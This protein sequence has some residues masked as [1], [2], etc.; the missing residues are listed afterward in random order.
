MVWNDIGY[1]SVSFERGGHHRANR[2]NGDV[3]AKRLQDLSFDPEFAGPSPLNG[4]AE[5]TM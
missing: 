5:W 2:R 1:E 4:P 3:I